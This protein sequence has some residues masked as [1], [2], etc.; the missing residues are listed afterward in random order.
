MRP[1]TGP[2]K[3]GG[4]QNVPGEK[5]RAPRGMHL[6]H[7]DLKAF[8]SASDKGDSIL[9]AIGTNIASLKRKVT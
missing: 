4:R 7:D 3:R 5:R 9:K 1:T 6:D 8:A 2:T